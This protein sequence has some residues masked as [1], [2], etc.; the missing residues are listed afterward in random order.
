MKS[1]FQFGKIVEGANFTNRDEEIKRLISN[2]E[3]NIHT[4][5]ISPRRWGKSS[6]VKAASRRVTRRQS[7]LKFC[8]I[9]LFRIRN[10]DEFYTTF[11]REVVK[12]TS[13]KTEEWIA[14]AKSFLTRMTPRFSFGTDPTHDFEM[15]FD[16]ARKTEAY[17]EILDLPE[18]IAKQRK[19]KIV[20]CIDEFQNLS[21]FQDPLLFQKRLRSVWQHHQHTV[22]C[23]YGSKR[24][25]LAHLFGN[26]S[27]PFYKFGDVLYL[28]K[29]QKAH[30][31]KFVMKGFER[32]GKQIDRQQS[33]RIVDWMKCHP[34]YVQQ[35]SH[36]VWVTAESNVS[37]LILE[38]ALNDLIHQSAILFEREIES[39]SNTQINFLRALS[40]GV[41]EA[42]SSADI[43][44]KY[45]LGTSGNVVK[46]KKSLEKKEMISN[47][48]SKPKFIDPAFELWFKRVYCQRPKG[49]M[50]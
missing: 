6:L 18:K 34:Y 39:L 21:F 10:E 50:A 46:I 36:M 7:D 11:A 16:F 44:K 45:H 49:G 40:E 48:Q 37:D 35:L 31:V 17:E 32:T 22:Y 30:L 42:L 1:P 26:K 28:D 12:A 4:L 9:D 27:M 43:L 8:Y 24:T 13:K 38:T 29:I 41:Q 3:N 33:E 2:F 14:Y 20:V 5:I 25:M 19:V 47:I 15:T 23:I